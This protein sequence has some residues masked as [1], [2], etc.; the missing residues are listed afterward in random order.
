VGVGG[1]L[2]LLQPD[3]PRST[4]SNKRKLVR[5]MEQPALGYLAN[6]ATAFSLVLRTTYGRCHSV[7]TKSTKWPLWHGV[8]L[9][10]TRYAQQLA[11][12]GADQSETFRRR[13]M[14]RAHIA[15]DI[16]LERNK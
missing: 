6:L 5:A 12:G 3:N 15:S 16:G 1:G 2:D 7:S 11:N 14:Y 4:A 8:I 10:T 9:E 13:A